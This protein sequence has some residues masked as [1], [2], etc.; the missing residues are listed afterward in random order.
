MPQTQTLIDTLRRGGTE[1]LG[2]LDA[3]GQLLKG[4]ALQPVSGLAGASQG[5]ADLLRG[6]G[7]D[8]SLAS[9]NKRIEQVQG[10]GG[11]P[12]TERGGEL[13][14]TMGQTLEPVVEK[15]HAPADWIGE[16]SPLAGAAAMGFTELADPTKLAG[17]VKTAS[18]AAK[19]AI[20]TAKAAKGGLRGDIE[21]AIPRTAQGMAP[22]VEAGEGDIA[23]SLIA[24]KATKG[25][26]VP[27]ST[28]DQALVNRAELRSEPP[29]LPK[30]AGE[31]TPEEW[32]AFGQRHGVNMTRTPSQ[33]LGISD[34][35]TR[36]EIMVPG[37]LEGK[38]TLP[39]VFEM[40]ANNFNPNA[41]PQDVHNQL[42]QK[43]LRTYDRP[44]GMDPTDQYNALNFALLSPNAPLT[45]NE[46]LAMRMRAK[47][48]EDL[49]RIGA[50][51]SEAARAGE[52]G[53]GAASRG[54][55]GVKGTADLGN[56]PHLARM[57]Q[58]HPQV[59]QRGEG[60]S[61]QDVAR[62]VMNQ[63]PG[64]GPKTA[65]LGVPWLDLAN[66]DTSAVDLHMIRNNMDKLLVDPELGPAFSE[67]LGSLTGKPG[68]SGE[69]ITALRKADPAF[70]KASEE[71]AISVI[72]SHPSAKYR[73]KGGEVNPTVHEALQP[74]KLGFE[75]AEATEF[76]PYYN[77]IVDYVSKSRGENPELPLFPEQWRLWDRYRNRVE[78]HEMAHPDI[79]KLPPMSW[80]EM[81]AS[82]GE[83]KAKGYTSTQLKEDYP[84]DWRKLAYFTA[85]PAAG[86]AA[87]INALRERE[88]ESTG[89]Q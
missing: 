16:R 62:R 58:E 52:M 57:L 65:S 73:L 36:K 69:Q 87:L 74:G 7:L 82:L 64:L 88:D 37:G 17:K 28:V 66:A 79:R 77:R 12:Q 32:A 67:R 15:L 35:D 55:M 68:M 3:T 49:A 22:L 83:H 33:S 4:L 29:T 47:G 71:A 18:R 80:E 72:S 2:H 86:S 53:T 43:F 38:F 84:T 63:V 11:G 27:Q 10:W 5:I 6:K 48:P 34:L 44:G 75:P 20:E 14:Q 13:L 24:E 54:G 8:E 30:P 78:P 46:F 70:D 23:K 26:T 50:T 51:T 42:M 45:Q 1:A 60:E 61:M 40:K 76:G 21:A 19:T 9:A 89:A 41:L 81:Q 59:F 39:D 85:P 25:P 56:Q 31:M